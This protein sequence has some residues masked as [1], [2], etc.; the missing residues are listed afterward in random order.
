MENLHRGVY[1]SGNVRKVTRVYGDFNIYTIGWLIMEGNISYD[2]NYL[3]YNNAYFDFVHN[4]CGANIPCQSKIGVAQ[5]INDSTFNKL[6]NTDAMFFNVNDT[7][8]LVYAPNITKDGLELYF[9]Q[10]KKNTI[11][12]EI[13]VSV[14]TSNTDAF[15]APSILYS[16]PGFIPEAPTLTLDKQKM[17]YHQKDNTNIFKIFLRYRTASTGVTGETKLI[18]SHSVLDQNFP[19]PFNPTT[20]IRYEL[21]L[22]NYVTLKIFDVLGQ[23]IATLVNEKKEA[24]SYS[25]QWDASD[26]PSGIYFYCLQTA[27]FSETKKLLL[28]K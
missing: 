10:L 13:C 23:E 5:K 24:G 21:P 7:N 20:V 18:P 8:Y 14:R 27:S 12:T 16:N 28:L 19:N 6:S 2:G 1:S 3:Y 9:T 4:S 15:G 26:L 11:N 22:N 25:V 17:Y